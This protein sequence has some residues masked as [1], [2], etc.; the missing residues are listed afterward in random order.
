MSS[1]DG[2]DSTGRVLAGRYE[3][4]RLLGSGG[5]AEV[6]AALDRRLGRTVAVKVLRPD[7]ARDESVR[8]RFRREAQSAASLNHPTV[9]AVHDTG[10]DPAEPFI[11]MEYV[12]G[13]TLR[14]V[15][16][17]GQ[18]MPVDQA[19]DITMGVLTALELAHRADIVHRDIKPGNIMLTPDG[20]VKV[21]DFGISRAL[22]DDPTITQTVVGTPAYLSPE[23]AEG[24]PVDVRSDLYST[25]C[26]LF[27][28]LT[29]RPPFVAES[30]YVVAVQHIQEEPPVPSSINPALPPVLDQIVGTALV[31][32]REL[33]YQTA[34]QFRADLAAV[35][36]GAVGADGTP[37]TPGARAEPA[38]RRDEPTDPIVL[39]TTARMPSAPAPVQAGAALAAMAPGPT[40]SA[41]PA[42][43]SAPVAPAPAGPF[44]TPVAAGPAPVLPVGLAGSDALAPTTAPTTGAPT[45]APTTVPGTTSPTM[46]GAA[47][48]PGQAAFAAASGGAGAHGPG[49]P[50]PGPAR[51]RRRLWAAAA[52]GLL[53]VGGVV[54]ALIQ[55]GDGG[56]GGPTAGAGSPS[57]VPTTLVDLAGFSASQA[58][59][60]SSV[61]EVSTVDSVTVLDTH[62]TVAVLDPVG[63]VKPWVEP[64]KQ[65]GVI[66]VTI[67]TDV[68][69]DFA[70]AEVGDGGK[71]AVVEA[72]KAAPDGA[73]IDVTGYTD[74]VGSD[75]TNLD[76]S[77]ARAAAV[78]AI[79]DGAGRG[80]VAV[81][82]GKGSADAV[83]P[84]TNADGS[85]NPEGRAKNRR[86]EIRY[87][88]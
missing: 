6:Y 20:A 42:T 9:V 27:E 64:E 88:G 60:Q 2:G 69:F 78:A 31:K 63:T 16:H 52:A 18:P 43:P 54:L 21:M 66:V 14:D 38:D 59:L 19:L 13:S 10:D 5:M 74:A 62:G 53:V 67:S 3:L 33:R 24:R 28:L 87:A 22:G 51:G 40:P 56:T 68:L 70:S 7:L 72:V 79:I 32:D 17:R 80:L 58:D 47:P 39:G 35:R 71:E 15:M 4:G 1:P 82:Q 65:G 49:A 8:V 29:G 44:P 55:S 75:Q 73:T 76:L 83:E 46:P 85:D 50:V 25:G 81:P 45:A 37:L 86:V 12:P 84:N 61:T 26:V 48:A 57:P 41:P 30:A 11:V 23:H 77:Q 34:A 36:A